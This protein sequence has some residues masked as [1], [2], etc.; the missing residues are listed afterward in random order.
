MSYRRTPLRPLSRLSRRLARLFPFGAVRPT[1]VMTIR[2]GSGW[3]ATIRGLSLLANRQTYPFNRR[4]ASDRR[5]YASRGR[6]HTRRTRHSCL[7]QKGSGALLRF[8][9]WHRRFASAFRGLV[10]RGSARRRPARR[11]GL[12]RRRLRNPFDPKVNLRV[13]AGTAPRLPGSAPPAWGPAPRSAQPVP[14]QVGS[15]AALPQV[16]AAGVWPVGASRP[17][18]RRP[19]ASFSPFPRCVHRGLSAFLPSRPVSLAP[20]HGRLPAD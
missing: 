14:W 9:G 17:Q 1:P 6:P 7:A 8:L 10:A 5:R 11:F 18:A 15:L 20:P 2:S 12:G 13:P 3:S 16:Q 4:L 19:E